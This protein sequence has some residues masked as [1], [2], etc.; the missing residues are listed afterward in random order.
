MP[1]YCPKCGNK[2][3]ESFKFCPDCG[4][5]LAGKFAFC[6]ECGKKMS[7]SEKIIEPMPEKNEAFNI[8]K[9]KRR[10]TFPKLSLHFPKH[11]PRKTG[12]V[13]LAIVCLVVVVGAAAV[14]VLSP[15]D[16]TSVQ[17]GGRTF[18][19]TVTNDFTSNAECYLLIDNLKQGVYGN[20]GFTV[21]A[22]GEEVITINEDDLM[23]Q[24]DA[25]VMKLFVTI[26]DIQEF[27]FAAA[28]TE[29]AEFIIDHVEGQFDGFY[30][31]CTSYL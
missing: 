22:R 27:G 26:D 9:E 25:Y 17:S 31:N 30:V 20:S 24:R 5:N 1:I 2:L 12:I 18:T 14:M 19:V 21:N 6:P 13:I 16:T 8:K 7:S 28:V 10:F 3:E 15:F 11:L 23:F 4:K 29:S